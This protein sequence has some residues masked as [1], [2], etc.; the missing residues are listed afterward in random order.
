LKHFNFRVDKA[1]SITIVY[2]VFHKYCEMWGAP[3]PRLANARIRG[4]NLMGFGVNKL[5]IVKE[6]D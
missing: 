5:P 4:D 6:R 3:E 1:S 2:C